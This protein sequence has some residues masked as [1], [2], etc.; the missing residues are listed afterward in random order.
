MSCC[1]QDELRYNMVQNQFGTTISPFYIGPF[2][3]LISLREV[4]TNTGINTYQVRQ[5]IN[6]GIC[7]C[8]TGLDK[9]KIST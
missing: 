7:M 9:Q 6:G 5:G 8:A 3:G 1:F 4:L 2:S